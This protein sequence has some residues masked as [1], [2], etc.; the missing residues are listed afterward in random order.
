MSELE[1][2]R[3]FALDEVKERIED[4]NLVR[5]LEEKRA[6]M[7]QDVSAELQ[8]RKEAMAAKFGHNMQRFVHAYPNLNRGYRIH[9]KKREEK[10]NQKH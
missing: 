2:N 4:L 1:A 7:M 5:E 9:L 3:G 8:K 6:A 10:K